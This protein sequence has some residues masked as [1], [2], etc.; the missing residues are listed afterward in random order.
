MLVQYWIPI[1]HRIG[2]IPSILSPTVFADDT[3]F[4][5]YRQYNL[6]SLPDKTNNGLIQFPQWFQL[7]LFILII[8]IIFV[9]L[10]YC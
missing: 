6:D 10:Y 9:L 4:V 3:I 8:L 7:I 2:P 5:C 1:L